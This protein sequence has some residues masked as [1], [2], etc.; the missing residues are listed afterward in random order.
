MLINI[1]TRKQID[2]PIENVPQIILILD[3][4][5]TNT[6]ENI[7]DDV[8]TSIVYLADS[9]SNHVSLLITSGFVDKIYYCTL[10]LLG[11]IAAIEDKH[12][13]YLLDHGSSVHLKP[14]LPTKSSN[15]KTVHFSNY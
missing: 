1:C 12:I 4:L 5:L 7:H 13:Q 9:S 3:V 15:I 14:L 6:D 2:V 10:R 11:N 8:F